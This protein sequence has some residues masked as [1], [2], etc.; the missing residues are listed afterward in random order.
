MSI[1]VRPAREADVPEM[2]R[3]L[4]ASIT[5]L[6]IADHANDAA[7][8]AA[9]TANKSEP[10]LREMLASP[11]IELHVAERGG[12]VV[13]VGALS[14]ASITLNYVDPSCRRM[15]VS[16][17][18]LAALEEILAH[19]G[20]RLATLRS[21]ATARNFYLSQGWV[22]DQPTPRGRFITAHPMHKILGR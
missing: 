17:V 9:W 14:G 18:L 8:I 12:Q 21:T 4:I 15:G 10:G 3:V 7:T 2:S 19:G 16:R 6:C 1:G 22:A 20:I 13:A 11:D 5:E